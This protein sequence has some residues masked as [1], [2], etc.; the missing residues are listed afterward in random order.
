MKGFAKFLQAKRTHT[1]CGTPQ[2]MAPEVILEAE[3][4]CQG[5]G[6]SF[7]ADYYSLGVLIYEMLVGHTP[8]ADSKVGAVYRK[9]LYGSVEF[10]WGM[11][12][13]AKDL[14]KSLL[15]RDLRKRLG[16]TPGFTIEQGIEQIKRHRWFKVKFMFEFFYQKNRFIE[17]RLGPVET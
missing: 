8:F 7:G 13:H 3:S 5:V 16:C 11:D 14:V 9:V 10:P 2:Y 6:Y 15:Q 17:C 1:F 4:E 12:L